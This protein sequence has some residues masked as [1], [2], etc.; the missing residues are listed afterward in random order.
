MN[1]NLVSY[2]EDKE[3]P[4]SLA[5]L[6]KRKRTEKARGATEE[7]KEKRRIIPESEKTLQCELARNGRS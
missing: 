3:L 1:L 5:G 4:W 7:F 6:R 2:P